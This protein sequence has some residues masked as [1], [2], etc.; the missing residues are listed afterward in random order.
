MHGTARIGLLLVTAALAA[1][2]SNQRYSVSRSASGSSSYPATTTYAPTNSYASTYAPAPVA[3]SGVPSV[4]Y[5]LARTD[6]QSAATAAARY[7]ADQGR[8][9]AFRTIDGYAITYDCLVTGSR[10]DAV[11]PAPVMAMPS[12]AYQSIGADPMTL[13]ADAGRYCA[14]Q[15]LVAT[16]RGVYGD[17]VVYDCTGGVA[18][19]AMPSAAMSGSSMPVAVP[20]ITYETAGDSRTSAEQAAIKYC[21]MQGGLSPVLRDQVGRRVT[22]ECR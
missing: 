8:T 11:T 10:A 17:R 19:T 5:D 3:V 6:R 9:A 16:Y 20:M 15:G 7:C 13:Q 4:T 18:S 21:N 12:I 14:S 22:Y 1:C 2:S